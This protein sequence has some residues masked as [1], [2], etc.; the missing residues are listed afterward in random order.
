MNLCEET[1]TEHVL[2]WEDCPGFSRGYSDNKHRVLYLRGSQAEVQVHVKT[3][4]RDTRQWIR[5][6][7]WGWWTSIT[8]SARGPFSSCK[9][10]DFPQGSALFLLC[11]ADSIYEPRWGY[12]PNLAN[13]SNGIFLAQVIG[14]EWAHDFIRTSDFCAAV[15]K[16]NIISRVAGIGS[17]AEPENEREESGPWWHP[18]SLLEP[19]M[20]S[21]AVNTPF[22]YSFTHSLAH[23]TGVVPLTPITLIGGGLQYPPL[24]RWAYC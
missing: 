20:S 24:Y 18:L 22:I 7:G 9:S 10:L 4:N 17:K 19:S 11:G 23:F 8:L 14:L 16:G 13:Q 21:A 15:E 5:C 6:R 12:N 3:A 2:N 1:F